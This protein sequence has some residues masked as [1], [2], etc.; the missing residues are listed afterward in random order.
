M[1]RKQTILI[2]A[3]ILVGIFFTGCLRTREGA[4]GP[5]RL[6]VYGLDNADVFDPIISQY[7]SRN[8]SVTVTYKKFADPTEFENLLIN[9]LAEGEGPDIFYVHNTWL[10]RHI[11]KIV[12]LQSESLTTDAY[13]DV[14]V[15]VASEDFI[16]PD[17]NDGERKIYA[18]PLYVD[19][20]ALYYNKRDFERRIP[21]RGSPAQNWDVFKQEADKFQEFDS[22]GNLEHGVIALGRSDNIRLSTD[23]LYNL[24]LQSGVVFY[25]DDFQ[26]A[27]FVSRGIDAF[28]YLLSYAAA[29]NK[30]YSWSPDFAR[31]DSELGE[32]E[33]FL[34]GKV[35]SIIGYS[36][37]YKR[38][39]NDLRNVRTRSANSISMS[40]IAV[41]P[42]PQ[43]E[44]DEDDFKVWSNYYGL[45]VSRNSK[46]SAA[47]WD[48]IQFA[49]SKE[50]ARAFHEKTKRPAARRDLIEDQKKEPITDVFVS[51]VGY[52]GSYRIFSDKLFGQFLRDAISQ[53]I[54][55][56]TARTALNDAQENINDILQVEAPNG[57]YPRPK[58]QRK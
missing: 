31:P 25:D 56:K 35:S 8:S 6:T 32:I 54:Q 44:I 57:L 22:D 23:I 1:K 29:Q 55:G 27:D 15:K 42:I 21:E 11:K 19:T 58:N 52:A 36:D 41:A 43:M 5:V 7:K 24:F 45:A 40:D 53:A 37:L 28:E 30:N 46:N 17:P 13:D 10:P 12:P 14:F 26:R 18:I 20:L 33:A 4:S 9:E 50:K 39:E 16:Q 47:A 49:T 38:L 2:L 48:F 51:Q 34:A 3:V